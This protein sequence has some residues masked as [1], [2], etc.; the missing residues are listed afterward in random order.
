MSRVICW[1]I[2]G[3]GF[4]AGEFAKG[5]LTLQD[6]KLLGVASRTKVKAQ[7]FANVFKI[8]RSYD[9]YEQLVADS[10]IDVIYIATPPETHYELSLLCLQ[11]GK[12][13]LCEK[14]FAL[15][16]KQAREVID[17]ARQKQLFC[18]EAMWMRFMPLIQEVKAIIDRGEIGEVK[19][20]MVDFGNP[21]EYDLNSRLFNAELGGGALLDR[22]VY[23]LSLA[24]YLLG[25][26]SS[27]VSNAT[28]SPSG[29]DEQSAVILNYPQGRL[30]ILS[31]SLRT[32]SSN[33]AAIMGTTGK[34]CIHDLWIR[35]DKISVTKFSTLTQSYRSAVETNNFK[36]KLISTVK[37][38][39]LVR[40]IYISLSGLLK[41]QTGLVRPVTANGYNY[42]AIEV[43]N[44]LR[45]RRLES[46]VMSLDDTLKIMEAMDTIRESWH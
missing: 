1:G 36:Q 5:L 19:M 45:N 25:E 14:P 18:M 33:E 32:Y 37:Q 8:E 29:A 35:P 30:A 10:A 22:G 16:A 7:E 38:N 4:V 28:L 13:I 3:T 31:Q 34:I 40:R 11:A 46:Q 44:C 20:L 43:M 39:S 24:Y 2:I 41:S 42:E 12:P 21:I 26:P 27:I 17:L 23:C 9:N 6:A 15:D